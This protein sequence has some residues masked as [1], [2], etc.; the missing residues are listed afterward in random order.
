MTVDEKKAMVLSQFTKIVMQM[1]E[2]QKKYFATRFR[3]DLHNSMMLEK[4]VD[5]MAHDITTGKA[6]DMTVQ[7]EL[8]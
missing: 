2:A 4:M 3:D 7:P 6:F 5:S 1:R 8:F